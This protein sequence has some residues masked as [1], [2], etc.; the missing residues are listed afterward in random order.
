MPLALPELVRDSVN[1]HS[2]VLTTNEEVAALRPSSRLGM[3]KSLATDIKRSGILLSQIAIHHIDRR[4]R[5][6]FNIPSVENPPDDK[7]AIL[8][9]PGY[10]GPNAYLEKIARTTYL[11]IIRHPYFDQMR[12]RGELDQESAMYY[13]LLVK[14]QAPTIVIAHS[15][16]GPTILK[17]LK[18]LQDAGKD[19]QVQ[20]VILIAPISDGVR[21][22]IAQVIRHI[23]SKTMREMC[24]GHPKLSSWQDLNTEN[25]AKIV[26][27]TAQDGDLFTSKERGYVD[28]STLVVA[29]CHDGHL[30]QCL[31]PNS[32]MFET[33]IAIANAIGNQLRQ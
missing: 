11:P 20:A 2:K 23:P 27:I 4:V 15:R 30:Q 33:T 28:G 9:A 13:E 26:V 16:G 21:D 14:R 3:P 12:L 17:A 18:L 22:E 24:P 5:L 32:I 7:A 31:D 25:R 8:L 6:A 1:S 10:F 29:D 19:D